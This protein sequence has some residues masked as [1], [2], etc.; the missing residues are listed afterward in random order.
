MAMRRGIVAPSSISGRERSYPG[1]G[2]LDRSD[3]A[4]FP[5][6]TMTIPSLGLKRKQWEPYAFASP[7][8]VLIAFV[9]VFRLAYSFYL[10]FQSLDL[11]VVPEYEFFCVKYSNEAMFQDPR[12]LASGWITAV[13]F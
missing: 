10:S 3:G 11:S 1:S 12:F 2:C 9:F 8:I 5:R 6:D 4:W 7:A 13:S